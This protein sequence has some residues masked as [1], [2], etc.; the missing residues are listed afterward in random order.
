MPNHRGNNL[1]Y[2]TRSD[3][4]RVL[5]CWIEVCFGLRCI[6]H[7]I[8]NS[9]SNY[10]IWSSVSNDSATSARLTT[11]V[12]PL[13]PIVWLAMMRQPCCDFSF[14]K[15]YFT[16]HEF[17]ANSRKR[18]LII[19]RI[20]HIQGILRWS[21]WIFKGTFCNWIHLLR[22]DKQIRDAQILTFLLCWDIISCGKTKRMHISND[23][24]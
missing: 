20:S 17:F 23:W 10:L 12:Y 3:I 18:S 15:N 22:Y 2:M 8:N 13:L 1:F 9:N 11:I 7:S 21:L 24:Y 4:D 14:L 5:D 6:I 19:C 16:K